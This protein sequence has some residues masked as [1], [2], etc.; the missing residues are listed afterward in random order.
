VTDRREV[1]TSEEVEL[2]GRYRHLLLWVTAM[3][4]DTIVRIPEVQVFG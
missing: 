3:P 4:A 1:G 2:D